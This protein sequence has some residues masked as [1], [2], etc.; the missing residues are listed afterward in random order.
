MDE[1]A[2]GGASGC[3]A[4][5]TLCVTISRSLGVVVPSSYKAHLDTDAINV[6]MAGP[7]AIDHRNTKGAVEAGKKDT[8]VA[9]EANARVIPERQ[10]I[11]GF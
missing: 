7:E 5:A 4:S 1:F 6:R 11:C 2:A 10:R 3:V 8:R 9:I